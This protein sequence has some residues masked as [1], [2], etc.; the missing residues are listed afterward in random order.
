VAE[1]MGPGHAPEALQARLA[2]VVSDE[3]RQ[4]DMA[5]LAAVPPTVD[6][7]GT[8]L[9]TPVGSDRSEPMRVE[10]SRTGG[11]IEGWFQSRPDR[12][13]RPIRHVVVGGNEVWLV[14][15]VPGGV[16][17]LRLVIEESSVS[18][19]LREELEEVPV[20]GRYVPPG[21]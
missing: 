1:W 3:E 2:Q 12:P 15:E 6:P 8:I 7:I 4:R 14:V 11:T 19:R 21:P 10:L 17:D 9:F 20:S 18:G 16:L 13:R 5:A